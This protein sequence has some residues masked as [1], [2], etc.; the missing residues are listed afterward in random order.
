M[1]RARR[2]GPVALPLALVLAL[3]VS[4]WS[5]RRVARRHGAGGRPVVAAAVAWPM[6]TL[7]ISEVQTGGASASDEFAELTNAGASPVDL[8][9]LELVYVTSTGSTVTRKATW[10]AST[11]LDPGR[12]LLVA[13]AAGIH[14][15]IADATYASGFAATGGA[16]VL[17]PVGGN[18][19][20]AVA[21][22]DATNAFV[23]GTAAPAPP[24]GSSL[25]RLPG[26]SAGNGTGHERERGR[27][28]G[29]DADRHRTWPR[30]RLRPAAPPSPSPSRPFRHRSRR[31]VPTPIPTPVPTRRRPR[32]PDPAADADPDTQFPRRPDPVATSRR[33][34]HAN[35]PRPSRRRRRSPIADARLQP[36]GATVTVSGVLTTDL[37]A[38]DSGR[39]G[40]VQDAT[41][42]IAVRL[43]AARIQ[44]VPAGT[45]VTVDGLPRRLLQPARPQRRRRRPGGRRARPAAGSARGDHGRSRRD[46][47]GHPTR[48]DRGRD[49]SAVGAVR[50][51]RDHDRRR[52]R[53]PP[54]RGLAAALGRRDRPDRRRRPRGRTA[55][56]AGQQRDRRLRL[57]PPRDAGRRAH[58]RPAAP[59]ADAVAELAADARAERPDEPT[60]APERRPV[61]VAEPDPDAADAG[62]VDAPSPSPSSSPA[63]TTIA[64]A[65]ARTFAIGRARRP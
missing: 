13:N 50:R 23:E 49:G 42:G 38:I 18:P 5:R 32:R 55:G 20:D 62:S 15:S 40:F 43:A 51:A 37:G 46:P 28:R 11:V 21:W 27:L 9:G 1:S 17:R 33:P 41:G 26:G 30:R 57:S 35:R 19:I 14:A 61:T 47:R 29:R 2:A 64:I 24:A 8:I 44:P 52:D 12:H 53:S 6:S 60:A 22:G 58:R 54:D 3:V 63:P 10:A 16:V 39:I 36:D 31:P 4:R 65:E 48:R 45:I 25:E 34:A 7:L 59:V 56:P